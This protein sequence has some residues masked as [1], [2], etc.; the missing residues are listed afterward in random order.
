M[1]QAWHTRAYGPASTF[2]RGL[3]AKSMVWRAT[4]YEIRGVDGR[5]TSDVDTRTVEGID[6]RV[7]IRAAPN[8]EWRRVPPFDSYRPAIS[9]RTL[10]AGP[11]LRF[12]GLKRKWRT[13]R[14]GQFQV[15]DQTLMQTTEWREF[16]GRA[17]QVRERVQE[18]ANYSKMFSGSL[19]EFAQQYGLLG[20]FEEDFSGAPV[21]PEGKSLVAP[22]ALI[23]RKGRLRRIDPASKGKE[24]LFRLL[25]P[26]RRF[27][28]GHVRSLA[29]IERSVAYGSMALPSEVGFTRR[30]HYL[31]GNLKFLA[32]PRPLVSHEE[33]KKI[34][35]AVLILDNKAPDG[36]SVLCT[37]EPLRRWEMSFRFFPSSAPSGVLE[38]DENSY[39]SLN[40]Y[41]EDVSPRAYIGANGNLER[42]WRYRSL[43]Q[44]MYVMLYLDLTG[45]SNIKKCQSRGCPDYFRAGPQGR[46]KYCSGRCANRASTRLGRG[47]EP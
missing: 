2:D 33:I 35:G 31:G 43:L 19:V 12:L 4:S 39:V 34:Y 8:A 25:E 11:H 16:L 44:A 10:A 7:V 20:L 37:Q 18:I 30:G 27:S 38:I 17:R 6:G 23:D 42:G 3:D 24:L 9:A 40:R 14:E 26:T 45:G 29:E 46:S 36:V 13:Y 15:P 1:A 32:E 5:P 47:Q 41:L 28:A 21:L 22:E